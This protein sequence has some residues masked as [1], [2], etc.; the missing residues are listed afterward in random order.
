[1]SRRP[2]DMCIYIYIFII[3]VIAIEVM[4]VRDF[5]VGW[6]KGRAVSY[7]GA[8]CWSF[9]LC[10]YDY[11]GYLYI[12][13]YCGVCEGWTSQ[14]LGFLIARVC[15]SIFY[16]KNRYGIMTLHVS[17]YDL[18]TRYVEMNKHGNIWI[19]SKFVVWIIIYIT[20]R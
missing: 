17:T 7:D 4:T 2:S 8:W 16:F 10:D 9:R 20:P 15:L 13:V 14:S 12:Y 5:I 3:C 6:V 19:Y 11:G 1:M 18:F